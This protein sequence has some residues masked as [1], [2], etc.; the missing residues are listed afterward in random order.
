MS[1]PNSAAVPPPPPGGPVE[2]A[3]GRLASLTARQRFA[4]LAIWIAVLAV[5]LP[6]AGRQTDRLSGGGW[7]VP[8]SPSDQAAR[9][10]KDFPGQSGV[11]LGIFV[12]GQEPAEVA[13]AV[14]RVERKIEPYDRLR[15]GPVQRFRD[16]RAALLPVRYAGDSSKV[17]DFT[18]DLR[19]A[20]VSESGGVR[21]RVLG[22]VAMWSNF[23]EVSKE[24]AA[25][26]ETMGFPVMLLILLGAFGTLLAALTPLALGFVAVVIT[27]AVI[28]LLSEPFEISVYVTN[29]A[30]M[31]GIGVAVDYSLFVVASYRRRLVAGME[32][33]HALRDALSSAGTAVLY[34]GATVIV[35][36][37]SIFL[38]DVNALRSMAA[39]AIIV[40][41]V[42]VL[43]TLTLL[44]ALLALSGSW[45]E[46]LR[47]RLPGSKGQPSAFWGRW[48]DKVMARP[49]RFLVLGS[50]VLIAL[51]SPIFAMK[52][53]SDPLTLLPKDAEV[54]VATERL[55][56][57]AGP[58][59]LGPIDVVLPDG[60]TAQAFAAGAQELEGAAQ[61]TPP[62]PSRDGDRYL[63]RVIRASQPKSMRAHG[64]LD[65]VQKLAHDEGGKDVVVGG[66]TAF[67]QD[68]NEAL[69]GGLW[70][71]ALF[72][73]AFSYVILLL[74]LRSALLP[75]KA[76][77]M[78][79][80]SVSAAYG[81]LVAVFQW[82]WFDWTGYNSPGYVDNTVPVLLL[83]TVFGLS[84]DYE[85]FLLTRIRERY[86]ATRDNSRAVSE[87]LTV[88]ARTISAAALIMIATFGSFSLAGTSVLKE[89]GIGL[90][91][92][93]LVDATVVRLALVPAAMRLLGDWN[94]WFFGSPTKRSAE[95]VREKDLA[96]VD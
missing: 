93:I 36:L 58:G 53:S 77:I 12:E 57:I 91:A 22:E 29:M 34:S 3:L 14:Q 33:F 6:L 51:A 25:H 46:R 90:A 39:G 71:I 41:A 27:G 82:G 48:S 67:T 96:L 62:L 11:P 88:S 7:D 28:Y 42:A 5:A 19:R 87:G 83:A 84:M 63:V 79:I 37:A 35:S 65:R 23:Q 9:A 75:L 72:V 55:S 17:Y 8:G 66:T 2:R 40:V 45:M 50:S 81:V 32:S 47:I 1:A 70:K 31:V 89:L 74:L 38:V 10:L 20:L 49:A 4:F 76:V 68:M 44:P 78:N 94:W 95:P 21:T 73:L 59:T 64:L 52:T 26:A 69:F 61:V 16:G 18:T 24:Q 56:K 54:R 30:S 85:V 86:L 43:A 92:A 15:P 80:L 60:S 13:A